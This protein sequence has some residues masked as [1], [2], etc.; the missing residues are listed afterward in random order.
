MSARPSRKYHAIQ[1]AGSA[2]PSALVVVRPLET[3]PET[4]FSGVSPKEVSIVLSSIIF[5][6]Q[7]VVLS[8]D[9]WWLAMHSAEHEAEQLG[10]PPE[11]FLKV[12][13][14]IERTRKARHASNPLSGMF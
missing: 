7:R 10:V 14:Q 8:H 12:K 11:Q 4:A 3:S 1:E 9:A 6:L 2:P 13:T 5:A